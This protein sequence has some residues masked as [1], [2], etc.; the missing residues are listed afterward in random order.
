[1]DLGV[2]SKEHLEQVRSADDPD[3]PVDRVDEGSRFTF[4]SWMRR[5]ALASVASGSIVTRTGRQVRRDAELR[6]DKRYEVL[7]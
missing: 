1:M 6:E 2:G 3:R 7:P 4:S 5:A